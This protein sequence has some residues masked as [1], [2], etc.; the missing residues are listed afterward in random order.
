MCCF[1]KSIESVS[2][3]R[4]FARSEGERQFLVY[5]MEFSAATDLAMILPVPVTQPCD[6]DSVSFINLEAYP[7]FFADMWGGI[8]PLTRGAQSAASL[9]AGRL[10]V[11]DVGA[12]EASF[13]PSMPDFCRLDERFRLSPDLLAVLPMYTDYGFSVCKLKAS[14][15]PQRIH[16]FAFSFKTRAPQ[17][18]FFPTVHIHDGVVHETAQFDH[19][20][21]CQLDESPARW[22]GSHDPAA[23]FMDV[24][25][26]GSVVNR[27][28]HCFYRQLSG[29][30]PNR[31]TWLPLG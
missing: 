10:A 2:G 27:D 9:S 31:D 25:K 17:A 16:P 6:E 28:Q 18:I 21:F 20:L 22:R 29:E 3:T 23:I 5:S 4:I 15:S 24:A 11:V 8:F 19:H 26:A 12:F 7:R 1:S 30:Y 14:H 13:V